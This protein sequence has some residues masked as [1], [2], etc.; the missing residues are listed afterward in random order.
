MRVAQPRVAVRVRVTCFRI[1]SNGR[2][3]DTERR[4]GMGGK[5]IRMDSMV[6]GPRDRVNSGTM[7]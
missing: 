2:S 4:E 7:Y 6:S 1:Y 5:A 3:N